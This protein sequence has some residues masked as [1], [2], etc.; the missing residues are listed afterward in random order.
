MSTSA[1]AVLRLDGQVKLVGV[2]VGHHHQSRPQN[3]AQL[4]KHTPVLNQTRAPARPPRA[5]VAAVAAARQRRRVPIG[6]GC[7]PVC[8]TY[9][10]EALQK[11]IGSPISKRSA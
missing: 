1:Q 6:G 9:S 2:C 3:T 10:I 8:K 7:P 4:K 5:A 11:P